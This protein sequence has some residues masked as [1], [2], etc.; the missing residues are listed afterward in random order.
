MLKSVDRILVAVNDLDAAEKNYTNVLG[1]VVID[2]FESDYLNARVRRM[3]LGSTEVELCMPSAAGRVTAH[4]ERL[5]EG[6]LYGG[7]TCNDLPALQGNLA[8]YKVACVE[9]DGR[10]Y[11][12]AC[13]LHGLPLVVSV[14]PVVEPT[15][16][17]G[18]IEFLYELTMV[19]RSSWK[20]IADSYCD[21][22]GL[23]RD[24]MVDITFKRFGYEGVLMLFDPKRLD[25]IELAEANDPAFPMGRFSAKRGDAFYMCYVQTDNLADV[26]QRLE[27]HGH[28]W[29]RRT[30]TPQEQD[31]LWIHPSALN[32]VLMGVSRSS[33]A[34]G[35]SGRPE[36]VQPLAGVKA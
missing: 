14:A 22:L 17:G 31:G 1:A 6:L 19:L 9:A 18:P 10:L 25:R 28:K 23:S 13:D 7:V 32:G 20:E 21:R 15:R 2:D 27:T 4:L 36:L 3:A 8:E 35:W 33:L 24:E 29:T 5:G 34:W 11:V 12:E 30:N 26:I 16:A